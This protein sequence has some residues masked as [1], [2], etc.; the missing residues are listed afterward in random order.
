MSRL[1]RLLISVAVLVVLVGGTV[2]LI[3]ASN[4]DFSGDYRLSG[5]FAQA[6][7]GLPPGAEVVFRGVQI[8]RVSSAVLHGDQAKVTMLINPSF[9]AH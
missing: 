6:G 9:E 1:A 7:E 5:I 2:T 8:G 3:R 4:G